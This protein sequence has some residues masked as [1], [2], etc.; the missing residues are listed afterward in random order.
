MGRYRLLPTAVRD[1]EA[2]REYTESTWGYTQAET[3]L[4]GL[5]QRLQQL[6]AHP[7]MAPSIPG[8][9]VRIALY[10]EHRILYRPTDQGIDIGRVLHQAK[11]LAPALDRFTHLLAKK[12]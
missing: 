12:P 4:T 3:Y 7:A 10:R 1:I 11:D 6:A 8:S 9:P 2:I 5:R